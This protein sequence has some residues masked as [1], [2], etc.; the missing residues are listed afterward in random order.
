MK[1]AEECEARKLIDDAA[2]SAL[3]VDPV[4]VADWRRRLAAEPII[5]NTRA[6]E[7]GVH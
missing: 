2:A 3:N 5:T 4:L 1:H 6:A 7:N